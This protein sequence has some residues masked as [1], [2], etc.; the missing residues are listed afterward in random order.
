MYHRGAEMR[1]PHSAAILALSLL[2]LF[3]LSAALVL[4]GVPTATNRSV[5][6][7]AVD[8]KP[9][10]TFSASAFNFV[11]PPPLPQSRT[12]RLASLIS[13]RASSLEKDK[14]PVV[15]DATFYAKLAVV[16]QAAAGTALIVGFERSIW[17]IGQSTGVK[18]PSAPVGMLAVFLILLLMRAF[19]QE[20]PQRV[21]DFFEPSLAFFQK[22][23]PL[24][25]SPPLVTLPA[26]LSAFPAL[27]SLKVVA[28]LVSGTF[29][30]LATTAL[31]VTV[32]FNRHKPV[33]LPS[34]P[35]P[36]E[37]AIQAAEAANAAATEEPPE[38]G[39]PVM[40]WQ[41]LKPKTSIVLKGALVSAVASSVLL[42]A[43][44]LCS[45]GV[46]VEKEIAKALI[47]SVTIS[48]LQFGKTLDP[49]V[50][51]FC[52]AIVTCSAITSAFVALLG[53]LFFSLD[54]KTALA[55]FR[56][57]TGGVLGGTGVG[58]II[59]AMASP[60]IVA[61]GFNLY[62]QRRLLQKNF[63]PILAGA[64]ST[65]VVSVLFTAAFAFIARLPA[66]VGLAM[67]PRFI[68]LP[69]AVPI[70]ESLGGNMGLAGM[71]VIIQGIVGANFG[72][73]FLDW[74]GIGDPLSR[75]V[76]I[77]AASHALGTASVANTEPEIS[78]P[79]AV[80]F[81][82]AACICA[83]LVQLGPVRTVLLALFAR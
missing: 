25:F 3:P 31:T 82:L 38:A 21:V 75:G 28:L 19:S 45:A 27:L 65:G 32:L 59:F 43:A 53:T 40:P 23:V 63:F 10:R 16:V 71:G 29:F 44:R 54:W 41:K 35:P 30:S 73:R 56:T 9:R 36:V 60:A 67:V 74:M 55:S 79:A 34:P 4:P 33:T 13:L 61:L 39:V 14:L 52:P 77:G 17:A 18:I 69:I 42:A 8:R 20:M 2:V 47:L 72:I 62:K 24:F 64:G 81:L 49:K 11:D 1:I 78:P 51:A 6:P 58:D 26:A 68:T 80:T 57:A 50:R 5:S 7:L 15:T 70:V 46:G 66:D 48:A 37:Q 76:A 12:S 22:G 83:A